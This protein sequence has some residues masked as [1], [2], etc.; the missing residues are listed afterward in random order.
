MEP[1]DNRKCLFCEIH[2]N[3]ADYFIVGPETSGL[4]DECVA[5][6]MGVTAVDDLPRFERLV[7]WARGYGERWQ[8]ELA[9]RHRMKPNG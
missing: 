8:D 1:T 4:C 5:H 3:Q 6:V 2:S 7:E 9:K